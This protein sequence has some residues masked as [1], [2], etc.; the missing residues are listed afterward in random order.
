MAHYLY[1]AV[2]ILGAVIS[3]YLFYFYSSGAVEDKWD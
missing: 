1:L 3:P 2:G